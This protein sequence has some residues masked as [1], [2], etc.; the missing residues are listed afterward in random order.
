MEAL[1]RVYDAVIMALA[2]IAGVILAASFVLIVYD[3][4]LRNFLISPPAFSVPSIE[5]GLLYITMFSGPWLVRT[6]GHVVVEALRQSLPPRSR[7]VL[8][9]I[10]YVI[11]ILICAVLTWKAIEL[12]VDAYVSG[13]DD[14]RAI[15]IPHTLRYG[16]MV[17]GF[18]LMGTEFC[19]YLFGPAS[20]YRDKVGE[21]EG[22]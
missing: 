15:Y 6:R 12:W 16:P 9:K 14:P 10:V 18:A 17:I 22:V 19:R 3:V 7:L 5:Y 4:V 11:C 20:F 1:T 2:A 13:E 21:H 8:E